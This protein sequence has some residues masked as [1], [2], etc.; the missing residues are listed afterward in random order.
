MCN[1]GAMFYHFPI[2]LSA[3]HNADMMMSHMDYREK[4]ETPRYGGIRS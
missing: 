3:G 1:F 2:S 4:K